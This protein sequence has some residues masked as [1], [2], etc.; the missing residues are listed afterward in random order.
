[1]EVVANAVS[2]EAAAPLASMKKDE[3]AAAE[4]RFSESRWIPEV[5]TNREAATGHSYEIEDED[6]NEVGAEEDTNEV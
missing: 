4:I 3:A 5:L 1:M 6:A 2:P